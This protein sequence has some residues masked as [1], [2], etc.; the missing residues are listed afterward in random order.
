MYTVSIYNPSSVREYIFSSLL[1]Q[2][3]QLTKGFNVQQGHSVPDVRHCRVTEYE[4]LCWS[5]KKGGRTAAS[6]YHTLSV[7][8]ALHFKYFQP[9]TN[10]I[11]NIKFSWQTIW[12]WDNFFF[13]TCTNFKCQRWHIEVGS[14]PGCF[15]DPSKMFYCVRLQITFIIWKNFSSWLYE[16]TY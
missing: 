15:T 12:I 11:E 2:F 7:C 9:Q 13:L 6:N 16:H 4:K 5:K 14:G 3:K 8:P 1:Y 10:L